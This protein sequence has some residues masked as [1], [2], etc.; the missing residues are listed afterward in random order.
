[1]CIIKK[2]SKSPR[3]LRRQPKIICGGKAS[4][5]ILSHP[6]M[7]QYKTLAVIALIAQEV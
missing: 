2:T 7:K 3:V 4:R 1:M 5:K 6:I